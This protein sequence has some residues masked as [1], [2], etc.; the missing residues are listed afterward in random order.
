MRALLDTGVCAVNRFL[1]FLANT[2]MQLCKDSSHVYINW[3]ALILMLRNRRERGRNLDTVKCSTMKIT[4][5]LSSG[6]DQMYAFCATI[7]E[8]SRGGAERVF[9]KHHGKNCSL[10]LFFTEKSNKLSRIL[11]H[12]GAAVTSVLSPECVTSAECRS[13]LV[14][15]WSRCRWRTGS[16]SSGPRPPCRW[17]ASSRSSVPCNLRGSGRWTWTATEPHMSP[18]DKAA[19][20]R[21]CRR[22]T[23][24]YR[25]PEP[26]DPA[27]ICK[28]GLDREKAQWWGGK[29]KHEEVQ[30]LHV[31]KH[32]LNVKQRECRLWGD[33]AVTGT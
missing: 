8:F 27:D 26:C 2:W 22:R 33:E 29:K 9:E 4:Q 31:D 6:L 12:V 30:N 18:G 5:S 7:A 19:W 11:P 23:F 14:R 1:F 13:H 25:S 17:P 32:D 16:W 21:G 10:H 3:L 15:P 28:Q 20:H 24:W